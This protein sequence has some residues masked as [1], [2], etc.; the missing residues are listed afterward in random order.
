MGV[1]EGKGND[2]W[3]KGGDMQIDD[4]RKSMMRK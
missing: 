1:I 2:D 4:E 3:R